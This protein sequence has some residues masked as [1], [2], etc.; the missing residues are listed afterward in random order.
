[1]YYLREDGHES[2]GKFEITK[3]PKGFKIEMIEKPVLGWG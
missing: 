3:T 2:G 1:M